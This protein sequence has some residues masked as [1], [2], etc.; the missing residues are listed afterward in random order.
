MKGVAL[1]DS[2]HSGCDPCE[3]SCSDGATLVWCRG[4]KLLKSRAVRLYSTLA[5]EVRLSD[6]S[7]SVT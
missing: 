5:N 7:H 1:R 4:Y 6:N 2:E 3:C